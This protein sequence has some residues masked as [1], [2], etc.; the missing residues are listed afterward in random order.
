[1]LRGKNAIVTGASG[2]IGRAVTEEFAR[3]GANV[4]ACCR[5]EDA[6]FETWLAELSSEYGVSIRQCV[7][8]L[9]D[10]ESM[11][12]GLQE[13]FDTRQS[14][15]ILVNNAGMTAVGT[16]LETSIETLR[17]TFEINY[18]S[19]IF[20]C[21][22]VFRRMMR[23]RSGAIVNISSAQAINPENG[24]LA[25][26]SSKAAFSL[27]TQLMAKEFAPFGIRVNAIAPGAVKT[28]LLDNYPKK[29]LEKYISASLMKRPAE[30]GEIASVVRFL[31]SDDSSFM[32]GQIIR[33]DGGKL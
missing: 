24:R 7:F 15:N 30:V 28:A 31:A 8:T 3:C 5:K 29:G 11:T 13:I 21:Q 19:Q 12:H 4:W 1:M 23:N 2:G 18:F 22:K 10:E 6:E 25:Y 33:V 14:I 26:A 9:G 17:R 20:I 32:T 27:A 16:V